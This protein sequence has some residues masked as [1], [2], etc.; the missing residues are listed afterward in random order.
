MFVGN[1][2]TKVDDVHSKYRDIEIYDTTDEENKDLGDVILQ[3]DYDNRI[4]KI[5]SD[6]NDIINLI[7]HNYDVSNA[8][9]Y[10]K[11]LAEKLY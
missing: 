1:I 10:L 8:L 3:E 6:I 2:F 11:I 7:E 9:D 4:D 5:K